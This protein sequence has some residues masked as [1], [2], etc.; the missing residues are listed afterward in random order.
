MKRVV[1]MEM[2]RVIVMMTYVMMIDDG[3]QYDDDCDD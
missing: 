1:L 3:D 2:I